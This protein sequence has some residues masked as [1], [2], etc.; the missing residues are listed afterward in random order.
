MPVRIRTRKWGVRLR[1]VHRELQRIVLRE[2][3]RRASSAGPSIVPDMQG[4]RRLRERRVGM[5]LLVRPDIPGHRGGSSI[6]YTICGSDRI[7]VTVVTYGRDGKVGGRGEQRREVPSERDCVS[8]RDFKIGRL[9]L[10]RL[11]DGKTASCRGLGDAERGGRR[12][13]AAP[14]RLL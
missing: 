4:V 9:R 10:R 8:V 7:C 1:R 13:C 14:R 5:V 12:A 2:Q 3:T 6:D 11:R